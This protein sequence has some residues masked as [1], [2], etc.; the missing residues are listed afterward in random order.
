MAREIAVD[1]GDEQIDV[2][3]D[4]VLESTLAVELETE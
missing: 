3:L 1:S 4:L 2:T